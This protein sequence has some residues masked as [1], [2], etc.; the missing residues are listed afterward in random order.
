MTVVPPSER[1]G[2]P[3]ALV[4]IGIGVHVDDD[5]LE[6]HRLSPSVRPV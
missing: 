4:T 3:E 2:K 5:G 6:G 1:L